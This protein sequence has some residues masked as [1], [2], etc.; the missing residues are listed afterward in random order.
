MGLARGYVEWI[1]VS[2]IIECKI[3]IIILC[4][5][6]QE[7]QQS[8]D[9][10]LGP[11]GHSC[12]SHICRVVWGIALVCWLRSV[13]TVFLPVGELRHMGKNKKSTFENFF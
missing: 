8:S 10:R 6:Q 7:L 5:R 4:V 12:D 9:S 13:T 1:N 2:T 11:P 3:M